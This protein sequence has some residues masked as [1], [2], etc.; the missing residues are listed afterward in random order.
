MFFV[1]LIQTVILA[2]VSAQGFVISLVAPYVVCVMLLEDDFRNACIISAVCSAAA[3]ALCGTQFVVM[4]LY[5]F[6]ISIV[7]FAL[8][9]KPLYVHDIF[10]A[11][12][13]TF[14]MSGI[15]AVLTYFFGTRTMNV[16]MLIHSALPSAAV[17]IVFVFILYPLLKRTMYREEKKK[18][19]IGDLV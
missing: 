3:G 8:R 19:L 17:N 5:I 4:T 1:F 7:V 6:Y 10:R 11:V 2:H 15:L 14:I 16:H 13:W 12:F 9:K 18:L